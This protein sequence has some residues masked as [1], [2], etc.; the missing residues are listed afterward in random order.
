MIRN[1]ILSIAALAALATAGTLAALAFAPTASAWDWTSLP[2]GYGVTDNNLGN[3][4]HDITV[5]AHHIGSNCDPGFQGALDA[6]IDS[7]IC[8]VNP[9]AGGA[10]CQPT[11]TA[12]TTTTSTAA[13]PG[14]VTTTAP[15]ATTTT[16]ATAAPVATSIVTTTT[17]L[18]T[19]PPPSPPVTTVT[20]TTTDATAVQIAALADRI[21]A[22]EQQIAA[23]TKHVDRIALAGDVAWLAFQQAVTG[24]A[25]IAAAADI[26]RGT[27]LNAV[28]GLG[29]FA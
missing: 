10:A 9:A 3:G 27:W 29:A 18:T 7:T 19:A 12:V 20:V 4:C 21:T 13:P 17:T 28:N 16:A 8:T 22:L 15:V 2:N 26:A 11:T 23:L 24:G 25:D 14:P 5:A 6:Y 1:R